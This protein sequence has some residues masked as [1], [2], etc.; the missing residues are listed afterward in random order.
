MNIAFIA[1]AGIL[2]LA[3]NL[4]DN[5]VCNNFTVHDSLPANTVV[6][7][8]ADT[9][10]MLRNPLTGWAIYTNIN[11]TSTYWKQMDSVTALYSGHTN[12]A[13]FANVLYMRMG[14][15]DFE[16]VEG[17][18]AWQMNPRFKDLINEARKRKMK[19]AFRIVVDSRDK[20]RDFS[21]SFVREAGA[22]GFYTGKKNV[23]T[24]YADDPV[25]Q[26]KYERFLQAFAK[27]FNDPQLVDFIDGYGLGKWG[28]SHSVRYL[29]DSNRVAVFN[30]IVDLYAR[31]FTRVPL[32][33]NY[34]RLIGTPQEWAAPDSLSQPL[35]ESAFR[36][37]YMLRHDAFGMTDYYRKYEENIAAKWFP[38]RPVIVEGGWLHNGNGYL[39]DPKGYKNWGDA[40]QGEYE[41][42]VKAH[43]NMMDLRDLKEASSWFETSLPLIKKFNI[44]GGYRLY[45]DKISLPAVIRKNRLIQIEHRWNNLG[46]GMCPVNLPQWNYK[47]KVAFA[48]INKRTQLAQ[49][50]FIDE[51]PDLSKW[52]LGTPM[53]YTFFPRLTSVKAGK[54]YWAIAIIDT[55]QNNKPGLELALGEDHKRTKEGWVILNEV[56]VQ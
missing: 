6:T 51:A 17:A 49:Y 25:F 39:K 27:E 34:H 47:Y 18:Y 38:Q 4:P 36:K 10:R 43:A 23:W 40:W 16:P 50:I 1:G 56:K 44:E 15:A 55:T 21:P 54:Y 28:E 41:E 48:L 32:A 2:S 14:W 3:A 52:L 9:Q 29:H 46:I 37:G 12:I 11:A 53:S 26:Q 30:W 8:Q 31:Y 20:P 24:P 22:Q 33:I 35:L 13:D 19:L 7:F 42:A 45:P 5:I